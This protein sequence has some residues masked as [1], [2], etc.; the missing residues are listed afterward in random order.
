VKDDYREDSLYG[1]SAGLALNRRLSVQVAY[2]ANRAQTGV[3]SDTD[4]IALGL[5]A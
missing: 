3:G 1:N 4:N 5:S 2:V